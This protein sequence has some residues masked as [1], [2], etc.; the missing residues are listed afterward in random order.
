MEAEDTYEPGV[1]QRL[2]ALLPFPH[3]PAESDARTGQTAEH[4]RE[5]CQETRSAPIALPS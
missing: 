4:I 1:S 5:V 3:Y 2:E